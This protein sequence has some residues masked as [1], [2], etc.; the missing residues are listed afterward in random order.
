MATWTFV[1]PMLN[2]HLSAAAS[3]TFPLGPPDAR[4]IREAF[5]FLARTYVIGG[6]GILNDVEA[7]A[8]QTNV[9]KSAAVL[10]TPRIGLAATVG[11]PDLDIYAVGGSNGTNP[12]NTLEAFHP[13]VGFHFRGG[14]GWGP[15]APMPTA[16]SGLAVATGS[17]ERIYAFGGNDGANALKTTEVY[18]IKSDTWS[19]AAPM[20]TAR[21]GVAGV[22]GPDGRIYAIGGNDGQPGNY[23]NSVEA[24]DIVSDTWTTVASMAHGRALLGAAMGSDNRIYAIG[25]EQFSSLNIVEAYDAATN[26]WAAVTPMNNPRSQLAVTVGHDG[27]I[28]AIGGVDNLVGALSSVEVFSL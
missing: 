14:G 28:Y 16:R 2:A 9:W 5:P 12:L 27:R 4:G 13:T 6:S 18:D 19:S 20:N 7:Y 10:P 17:N 1:A 15:R 11:G 23:L 24:Y 22:T 3:T 8:T 21:D 26:S 25:G